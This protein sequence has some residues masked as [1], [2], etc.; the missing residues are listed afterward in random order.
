[1]LFL[2]L[3]LSVYIIIL[4]YVQTFT[5]NYF[6]KETFIRKIFLIFVGWYH[7]ETEHSIANP[8]L[9]NKILH[10]SLR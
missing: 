7:W 6:K 4:C 10:R 5:P 1:M 2:F 9:H 3:V 8:F